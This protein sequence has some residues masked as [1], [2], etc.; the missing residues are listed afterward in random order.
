M[1]VPSN[2]H[3]IRRHNFF[4]HNANATTAGSMPLELQASS[5]I[6]MCSRLFSSFKYYIS[7]WCCFRILH[8]QYSDMLCILIFIH[9][10]NFLLGKNASMH[11]ADIPS[12]TTVF[13]TKPY[14]TCYSNNKIWNF[15]EESLNGQKCFCTRTRLPHTTEWI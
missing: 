7:T 12:H 2:N 10:W 1:P 6:Q 3:K 13:G 15:T 9:K 5:R 11:K 14:P 4:F 8:F